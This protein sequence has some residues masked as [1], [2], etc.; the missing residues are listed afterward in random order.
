MTASESPDRDD[1]GR[2]EDSAGAW[3][4]AAVVLALGAL[5]FAV[6]AQVRVSDLEHRVVALERSIDRTAAPPGDVG[7]PTTTTPRP[8][9]DQPVA[10]DQPA[11]PGAAEAAVRSAF[12][13]LYDGARPIAE[14]VDAVDDPRGVADALGAAAEGDFALKVANTRA[15]VSEVIFTSPTTATTRY[16][17]LVNGDPQV[18]DAQGAARFVDGEWKVT[19]ATV[20][21]DLEDVG[22]P[23]PP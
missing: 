1:R 2:A 13:N 15:T 4:A 16:S 10:G 5:G 14:R 11:N 7:S 8:A 12:V 18:A 19:R 3:A 6:V 22:A 20:C 17:V 21:A 9:D 23:C